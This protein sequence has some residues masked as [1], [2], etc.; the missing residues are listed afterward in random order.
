MKVTDFPSFI[1]EGPMRLTAS[2]RFIKCEGP[3]RLTASLRFIVGGAHEVNCFP[4]IH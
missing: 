2:L 3:M 4:Q 1:V